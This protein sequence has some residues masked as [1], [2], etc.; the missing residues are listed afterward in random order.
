METG[1]KNI[2]TH[3]QQNKYRRIVNVDCVFEN[4]WCFCFN[5]NIYIYIYIYIAIIKVAR[6][7]TK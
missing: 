3:Q 5:D 1:S 6:R 2:N 7:A 4:E